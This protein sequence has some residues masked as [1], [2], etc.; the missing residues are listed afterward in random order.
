MAHWQKRNVT[1]INPAFNAAFAEL[2]LPWH[3]GES[4]YGTLLIKGGGL[5]RLY[6][7]PRI[8]TPQ[9][10]HAPTLMN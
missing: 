7:T 9:S 3:W 4:F 2:G 5:E 8:S 10:S 6:F 1:A